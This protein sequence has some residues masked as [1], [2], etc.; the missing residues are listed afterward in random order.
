MV[1]VIGGGSA[2]VT[3]IW[4]RARLYCAERFPP[5]RCGGRGGGR[6]PTAGLGGN[7]RDEPGRTGCPGR[8]LGPPSEVLVP[9]G[10]VEIILDVVGVFAIRFFGSSTLSRS[11]G[12]TTRPVG[13]GAAD[14][15]GG[16]TDL[17]GV[18]EFE[19][20]VIPAGGVS[21]VW[22]EIVFGF[23]LSG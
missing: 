13:R 22:V 18:L 14:E 7:G 12:G 23:A 16:V 6:Y 20:S 3:T 21:V 5:G 2:G 17:V 4:A 10:V 11:V 1:L 9:C 15:L 19:V 8:G